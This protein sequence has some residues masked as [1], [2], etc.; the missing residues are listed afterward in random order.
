MGFFQ[1]K[2]TQEIK[3]NLEEVWKFIANPANLKK[4]TPDYMGFDITSK[5]VP[6]R[7]YAGMIISYK[8]S[9]LLG[10]KTTWVTEITHLKENSYFVDEQR[11]GPYSI[12]HHQ[13]IIESMPIGTLMTDIVSYQPPF[14]FL[15]SIANEVIIKSKLNEIFDYR[16]KALDEIF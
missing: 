7:M 5:D 10:I 15:G 9:P 11:V 8:V 14:G 1:F 16:T 3:A 4:I 6:S 2:R 13:H 12:W